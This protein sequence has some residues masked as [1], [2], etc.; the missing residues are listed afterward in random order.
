VGK[1]LLSVNEVAMMLGFSKPDPVLAM[2][3]SGA[4]RAH[5]VAS[6]PGRAT[7]RILPESVEKFLADREFAPTPPS[8]RGRRKVK[9]EVVPEFV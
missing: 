8:S 3:R 6:R 2:I 9:T 4:I 7:W 1:Q 5:N